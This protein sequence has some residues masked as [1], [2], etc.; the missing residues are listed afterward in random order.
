METVAARA[1]K[2]LEESPQPMD[3]MRWADRR[4]VAEGLE[5]G[6]PAEK[7]PEAWVDHVIS[8]NLNLRDNLHW[9]RSRG[10]QPEKA[11]TFEDLITAFIP[12]EGG[13]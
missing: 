7:T 3:L 12:T 13:L 2:L 9:V 10:S 11:E 8:Q 1:L 6:S 4:L 5:N